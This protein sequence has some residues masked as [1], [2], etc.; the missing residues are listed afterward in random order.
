MI[1][2]STLF[3]LLGAIALGAAVYY[4]DWK[5]GQKEAE[6]SAADTTKPAFSI[7]AGSEIVSLVISRPQAAGEAPTHLEKQNGTWQI[8]QPLQTEA[9]QHIVG[10]IVETLGSSR[11]ESN[12]PGTPDRLKAYGLD[13]PAVS[14]E[15]KLQNGTQHT[16]KLG[17]KDF[18]NTYVYGLIDGKDAALLPSALRT[19]TD[20]SVNFLRDHDVLHFAQSDVNSFSLKNP[21]GQIEAKKEKAG[22]TF[23]KPDAGQL[24]DD[25]DVASL[26][27][28]VTGGKMT[29]VVA[30]SADN[31]SKYGLA[32]PAITFTA[33]EDNGKSATLL[34]GKKEGNDYYAKDSSR[35]TIFKV[36]ET[37]YKKLSETY[38][39]LRDKKVVHLTQSDVT[40]AELRNENG[41]IVIAPKSDQ[42]WIAE[43][44]PELKGKAV[45]TW[46]I[47]P[48]VANTRA[49]AIVDH[50]SAEIQAKLAKP[51]VQV[52]LTAK[53]GKKITVSF[54]PVIE[55]FVYAK[56]SDAPTVYKLNKNA[57]ADLNSKISEFAIENSV[58]R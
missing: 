39:D 56:T 30:E 29:A 25:S 27:N 17:N 18:T 54:T 42:D 22:W 9:D 45:A 7:P 34:V 35:P 28:S 3:I 47:F 1:K 36:N 40:H 10:S 16:L 24:A 52:T 57:L 21:A 23:A 53:D 43:A 58:S 4:F 26:L 46:K 55:D 11:I 12:Q 15:F 14:V 6:K 2:K 41:T 49:L 20:L 44:P 13:P 50:P 38:G 37:L 8:L 33:A 5:R 31:L 51:L 48:S 19:Q 32:A